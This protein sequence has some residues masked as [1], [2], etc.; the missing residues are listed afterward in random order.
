MNKKV[1]KFNRVSKADNPDEWVQKIDEDANFNAIKSNVTT[2]T[3]LKETNSTTLVKKYLQ[4][5][6][7]ARKQKWKGVSNDEGESIVWIEQHFKKMEDWITSHY[8]EDKHSS[9]EI[10]VEAIANLLLAIDKI[11]YR[12]YVR[13]LFLE[14]KAY[15]LEVNK[16]TEDN[17]LRP[18]EL[19]NW[20]CFQDIEQM[21]EQCLKMFAVKPTLANN[22]RS[23][24]LSLLTLVPPLRKDYHDMIVHRKKTLPPNG[25]FNYI[26]EYKPGQWR[27]VI[28]NDKISHKEAMKKNYKRA[29]FDLSEEIPNITDGKRLNEIIT[30]SL[31]T[32]PRKYLMTPTR[33]LDP[34]VP[35]SDASYNST[36]FSIFKPKKPTCNLF[37]KA[38]VNYHYPK[39]STA[40]QTQVA[41]R[42]RHSKN[43]ALVAYRKINIDCAPKSKAKKIV[44]DTDIVLEG[45]DLPPPPIKEPVAKTAYFNAK[46]H[47]K[48][49][50]AKHKEAISA[51]RKVY[52]AEN[53]DK[54]LKDKILWYLNVSQSVEKPSKASIEKYDIKYDKTLKKWV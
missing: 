6:K 34:D 3:R 20:I 21:R 49:Y 45:K 29:V 39:L 13:H 2:L 1:L 40:H 23:L 10:M 12:E 28:G 36:L 37:R 46:E 35:M 50:R 15:H 33:V 30:M 26:W 22:M 38:Y 11:K 5:Y 42:M 31:D 16:I 4:F 8:G 9:R 52:Y 54:I 51:R 32:H 44:K 41:T 14:G 24:T 47:A 18:K 27:Y 53:K 19:D 43:I 25:L 48:Q 7:E 17:K